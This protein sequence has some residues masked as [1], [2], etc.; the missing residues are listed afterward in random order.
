M[1]NYNAQLAKVEEYVKIFL[2]EHADAK[3]FYHNQ[4][5]TNDVVS[6]AKKIAVHYQLDDRSWFVVCT[7]AW[8]HDTGYLV[9]NPETHELKSTE[10]AQLFLQSINVNEEE[11]AA[12]KKCIM[13]TRMPQMPESLLEQIIC[14][15]DLFY[16]GTDEFNER[17]KRLKK[18]NE[19]V[20][21]IKIDGNEWRAANIKMLETYQYHTDYCRSLLEKNKIGQLEKMKSKQQEK[22][23]EAIVASG[24]NKSTENK[25]IIKSKKKKRP[26]KGIE[27]MFRISTSNNV[28]VSAMAD[29]KAHI[30][31]TVNSIIISVIAGLILRNIDE[32]RM[33]LVPSLI[34]LAV[35]LF[36]IIY[37]ILATRPK[38]S[39]GVFTK[40]QVEKKS[41]N[42]LYFGSF[43][44][45]DFTEYNSAMKKMMDDSEFLYGS[46]TKDIFWQG[47]VLGRKY[48]LL[49]ISY[50][51]FL[52]GI[53][54]SVIAFA[55]AGF[56]TVNL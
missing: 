20:K 30:M 22:L 15:A 32:N 13:A 10:L 38:I 23:S 12:I 52:Y 36:T 26:E 7:A 14:D 33:L 54:V 27:T 8:F 24:E 46:L 19:A 42:L 41:V 16:L 35:S 11:I 9:T 47:K 6:A 43:Y 31:I 2:K 1:M 45:M 56:F 55:V 50:T 21:N 40:E 25:D 34:L 3:F 39:N 29:N 17:R 48:R 37:S 4:S 28:R 5:H 53:V 18:E 51:I 44:K 49:R